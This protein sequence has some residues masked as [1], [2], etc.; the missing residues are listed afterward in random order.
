MLYLWSIF[1]R[2]ELPITSKDI[3][4]EL[5]D[6]SR[7]KYGLLLHTWV[8]H[9][10]SILLIFSMYIDHKDEFLSCVCLQIVDQVEWVSVDN[11]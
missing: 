5:L 6:C 9:W 7:D 8:M 10:R 4:L 11:T 3:L 1:G 2:Y